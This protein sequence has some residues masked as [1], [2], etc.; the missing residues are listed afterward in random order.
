MAYDR[1]V[2]SARPAP[3]ARLSLYTYAPLAGALVLRLASEPT[4]NLS[5]LALAAYALLGRAHAIRALA[6]S[7]LFTVF[8]PG[9]A[10][11]ASA[12]SVGRYAVLAAAA[13]SVV[14]H[15]NVFSRHARWHPFTLGTILLGLFIVG[16]SFVVSPIVDV[17]VLKAVS[18][19]LAMSTIVSAWLG[20]PWTER[21][22]VSK[23]FFWGL[24]LIMAASLPF[25]ASGL[26]YLRN[27][28]GFQGILNH[29]QAFGPTM[30][31][32]C[33]WTASRLFGE[34]RPS[35]MLV[36][37]AGVSLVC[38]FASEARTAGIALV[39]GVSAAILVCPAIAGQRIRKVAP[40]LSSTR[41]WTVFGIALIAGLALAPTL[42]GTVQYYMTKSGRANAS[43]LLDAY[44]ISRGG[45]MKKMQDNIGN[46]PFSGIGFGIASE[47]DLMVVERDSVLGLPTGAAIEKGVAPLAVMEELGLFGA[48]VVAF[49]VFMIARSSARGGL[50]PFATCLTILALNMGEAN[51]FSPGGMGLLSLILLGW[52]H[53]SGVERITA[54]RG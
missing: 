20:M 22:S 23:E 39:I 48:I 25:A 35:W 3:R 52:A 43:G 8:N 14:I 2:I 40:G 5:Y 15:G 9:I 24:V 34:V 17:S 4:A 42:T 47:P 27:E 36:G 16:H 50:A 53:A 28:T 37:V 19:M 18:W 1:P 51:L 31:L 6:M 11:L 38:I 10:P 30:A 46:H 33:C 49:W 45:L 44:S 54:L 7:W 29:P 41:V 26:G 12:G 21:A 32:L 13:A